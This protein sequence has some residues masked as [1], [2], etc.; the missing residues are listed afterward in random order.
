MIFAGRADDPAGVATTCRRA[1]GSASMLGR[2][3]AC[4]SCSLEVPEGANFCPSCGTP[5]RASSRF[6]GDEARRVVTVLFAD[7]V[8][9]TSLSEHRDPEQ[10]KRLVDAVFEQLVAD[11]E[12]Y[13]GAVDKVLGDAIVALFGAPVAH[14]D[15]AERAVRAG[16][17]MQATLRA[18]RTAQTSDAIEMRVGVNTGEVLVGTVAGTDYTAMGDVVNTAAR[19]QQLAAAGAVYV[20]DPTRQLCSE[21]VR[22]RPLDDVKLRGRTQDTLVWEA[23]GI[24]SAP[25]SRQWASDV[26]FVGRAAEKAMLRSIWSVVASG[27]SAIVTVAGEPGIGKSRLV[28]EALRELRQNRPGTLVIEGACA[29][30]GESNVWWPVVGGL[31]TQLGFNRNGAPAEIRRRVAHVM[32]QIDDYS[33][34]PSR[35]DEMVELVMHLLGQPS[36]LD[37]LGPIAT[38]DAVF[39]VIVQALRR[40]T[41]RGPVVVWVDDIQWASPLLLELLESAARQLADAPLLIVTTERPSEQAPLKWP[42][43][44]DPVLTLHL[45]LEALDDH[46]SAALVGYAA[47]LDLTPAMVERISSRSG[48]NPL[49]LIELA[50]MAG[51]G[52]SDDVGAELPGSMRAL[53]AARLDELPASARAVVDNAAVLG[54]GGHVGS[55]RDFAKALQQD[56]EPADLEQLEAAGMLV[57]DGVIWRF[58]SDVVREVAYRTLTKQARAQRHAGVASYLA[59]AQP[60]ELDARAHHAASAAELRTELGSV[61]GV[62]DDIALRAIELSA[63]AAERWFHQGAHHRGLELIDRALALPDPPPEVQRRLLLLQSEGLVEIH[64]LRRART[65]LLDL[66]ERA[67]AAGD[68]VTRGETFRLLGTIEQVEGDLVASRRELGRAVEIFRELGD[69]AYLAEALRARGYA[70]VFGGSLADAEWFLGEAEAIFTTID[71]ARGIAWVQQNRAWVSFLAGDHDQS[72][73]RLDQAIV[74]FEAIG[75]RAGLN[76]SRGLLAYVHHFGRNT[77]EALELAA[78]VLEEARNWGDHFAGALMLN[79]QA[80]V[81]LWRGNIELAAELA[82]DALA[83]FRKVDD[84]FGMIQAL[85][86][87]NRAYVGAGRFAEA[88]RS[89]EEVLVLS[90]AFGAMAFPAIAAA[91]ASMHLGLGG[92]AAEL[93]DEAVHRLDTTGANVDEGRV[94]LAFGR[95]LDGDVDGAL[96]KLVE[97]DVEAS[98]FALAARATALAI[99]GDR[100]GALADVH[101]VEAMESVSYWDRSIAKIAGAVVASGDEAVR[102]HDELAAMVEQLDDV[103]VVAYAADVLQQLNGGGEDERLTRGA[104]PDLKIGGWRLVAELLTAGG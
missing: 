90:N 97:V 75:D 9:F 43:T 67:D 53:I 61:P 88:N 89:V 13:G 22:F 8:G 98:P 4:L 33:S 28:Y 48:G 91:G 77:E 52:S 3:S 40:R 54:N 20:G 39:A 15:D 26:E 62:V 34:D 23:V 94:V 93:A 50:R 31:V 71:D 10:V 45:A 102:R 73:R 38:R 21:A 66:A 51:S 49:F 37:A 59:H 65:V 72:K 64:D 58:R 74:D 81:N 5:Q 79:L 6:V 55:L 95:L 35:R 24:E 96:A 44:S 42:P 11:V 2:L 82:E 29:P 14:E 78:L 60:T 101:A 12:A 46:E 76:W 87:L 18:I 69:D 25:L 80:S 19:L 103:V 83:G 99:V 1:F 36:T 7:L 92:R 104:H 56:F 30:Y 17:A 27:R 32:G 100:E 68:R 16:L 57:I 47:G 86:T 85:S 70:E 84:R 41:A 63:D